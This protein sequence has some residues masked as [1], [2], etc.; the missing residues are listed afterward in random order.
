RA[1]HG[2]VERIE[3]ALGTQRLT[4]GA[5]VNRLPVDFAPG[6][7]ER[8]VPPPRRTCGLREEAHDRVELVP[9]MRAA[10][11]GEGRPA[12]LDLTPHI[13]LGCAVDHELTVERSRAGPGEPAGDPRREVGE[14][15]VLHVD[16]APAGA[17]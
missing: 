4:D 17:S 13:L 12:H 7:V 15:A 9:G 2:Y 11:I 8:R 5:L 6:P 14:R 10:R 1:R 16:L 3:G